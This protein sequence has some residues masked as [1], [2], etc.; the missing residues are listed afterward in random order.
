MLKEFD[1]RDGDFEEHVLEQCRADAGG[2]ILE[3]VEQY[4]VVLS[5][6]DHT[7]VVALGADEAPGNLSAVFLLDS[8]VCTHLFSEKS[9]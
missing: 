4:I 6:F 1:T 2:E 8:F 9:K 7:A 5:L 3:T